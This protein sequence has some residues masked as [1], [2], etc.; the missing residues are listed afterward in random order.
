MKA[1]LRL[2]VALVFWLISRLFSIIWYA[3]KTVR[4]GKT[5]V[6]KKREEMKNSK[7]AVQL[8]VKIRGKNK[9]W[10]QES[11]IIKL[12]ILIWVDESNN[13]FSFDSNDL[14]KKTLLNFTTFSSPHLYTFQRKEN[15]CTA[16]PSSF[17]NNFD[18][19]AASCV[20]ARL[21]K[22]RKLFF[23]VTRPK[24]AKPWPGATCTLLRFLMRPI[25]TQRNY[26]NSNQVMKLV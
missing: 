14:L 18:S 3:W 23:A 13:A 15:I 19:S 10:F 16:A 21:F 24:V 1:V 11:C 6:N 17:F 26:I 22:D 9:V 20:P 8:P 5:V 25:W 2:S 12:F 7:T 4:E